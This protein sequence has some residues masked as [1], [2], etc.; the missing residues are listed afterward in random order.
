MKTIVFALLFNLVL[1]ILACASD[2]IKLVWGIAHSPYIATDARIMEAMEITKANFKTIGIT[3]VLKRVSLPDVEQ[4]PNQ[5]EAFKITE[6]LNS[7]LARKYPRADRTLI[8]TGPFIYQ[9]NFAA[10]GDTIGQCLNGYHT[11]MRSSVWMFNAEWPSDPVGFVALVMGHEIAHTLGA[12][13]DFS[14]T[15]IMSYAKWSDRALN[16]RFMPRAKKEIRN[17]LHFVPGR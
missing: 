3:L 11:P 2:R 14:S 12:Q 7:Y 9:G 6:R 15:N 5:R 10:A 13:H 1:P 4:A 8:M 16:L 17:C